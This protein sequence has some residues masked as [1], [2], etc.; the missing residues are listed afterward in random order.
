[1]SEKIKYLICQKKM[2]I[3]L[4]GKIKICLGIYKENWSLLEILLEKMK[5]FVRLW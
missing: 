4:F 3:N 1:M 2:E 5:G